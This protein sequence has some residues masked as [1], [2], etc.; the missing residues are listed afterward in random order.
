M[1]LL[2]IDMCS[3]EIHISS[4][5]MQSPFK[6][7]SQCMHICERTFRQVTCKLC[8]TFDLQVISN[9]SSVISTS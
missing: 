6:P 2:I 1:N 5:V 8:K 7:V 3:T 4:S 9:F